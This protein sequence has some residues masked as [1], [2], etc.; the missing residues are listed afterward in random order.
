MAVESDQLLIEI[1]TRNISWRIKAAVAW[2]Q[3]LS[4]A[5][6]LDIWEPQPSVNHKC[7]DRVAQSATGWIVRGSNPSGGEIFCTR[8]DR[9]W[10]SPSLLYN[11]YGVFPEGKAAR[12]W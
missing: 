5:D 11:G 1:D 3:Q 9:P 7:M 6:F 4:Y 10:D 2:G 8:P 12:A